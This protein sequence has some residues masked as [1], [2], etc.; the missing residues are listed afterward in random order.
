M[1]PATAKHLND[2]TSPEGKLSRFLDSSLLVPV[3]QWSAATTNHLYIHYRKQTLTNHSN[4][5]SS[6]ELVKSLFLSMPISFV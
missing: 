3:Q 6:L 2:A 4:N 1:D 5:W